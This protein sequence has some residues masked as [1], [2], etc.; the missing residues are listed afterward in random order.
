M[1]LSEELRGITKQYA[2][3]IIG[4]LHNYGSEDQKERNLISACQYFSFSAFDSVLFS[5]SAFQLFSFFPLFCKRPINMHGVRRE[6][7]GDAA[8]LGDERAVFFKHDY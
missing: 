1:R 8:V 4:W 5:M 2:S 7:V 6:N 3:A